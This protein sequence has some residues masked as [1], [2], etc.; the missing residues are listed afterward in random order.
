MQPCLLRDINIVVNVG[1]ME[2][3]YSCGLEG[4]ETGEPQ[5]KRECAG[6]YRKYVCNRCG[7]VFDGDDFTVKHHIGQFNQAR[8][9]Y[10]SW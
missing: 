5:K 8:N 2:K 10:F 4:L 1:E 9:S 7:Q 6:V 3:T